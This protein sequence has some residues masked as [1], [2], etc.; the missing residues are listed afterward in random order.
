MNKDLKI[1]RIKD[2]QELSEVSKSTA[3]KIKQQ[4]IKDLFLSRTWVTLNDYKKYFCV[5]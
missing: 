2:I 4:I 3:I 1:L 5:D